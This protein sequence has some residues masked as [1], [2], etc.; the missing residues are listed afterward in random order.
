MVN[1]LNTMTGGEEVT[2]TWHPDS[3]D[4][5]LFGTVYQFGH[6]LGFGH[7]RKVSIPHAFADGSNQTRT[8]LLVT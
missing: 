5:T 1:M 2:I 6:N 8:L 3:S 7:N 4:V